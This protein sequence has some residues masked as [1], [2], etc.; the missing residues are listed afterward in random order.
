MGTKKLF[1]TLTDKGNPREIESDGPF[2]CKWPNTWLGDGYYLWE[3]Y[4]ENAHWWGSMNKGGYIIGMGICDF[5][6]DKCFDLLPGSDEHIK[7]MREVIEKLKEQGLYDAFTTTV[8]KVIEFMKKINFPY[9]AIRAYGIDSIDKDKSLNQPYL[10]R[11]PFETRLPAYLDLSPAIQ[12]CLLQKNSLNFRDF[13]V[14]YPEY[15]LLNYTF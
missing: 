13:K 12:I 14:V 8:P 9:E 15:Y 4:I 11:L 3:T 7:L 1:Q 10:F 6:H 5:E 2:P